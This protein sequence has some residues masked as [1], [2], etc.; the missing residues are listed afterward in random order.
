MTT[1]RSLNEPTWQ[2][3]GSLRRELLA[4]LSAGGECGQVMTYEEFLDW[5]D[6][7]TLAE[8]VDGKVEMTSPAGL[9]HQDLGD[10][11]GGVLSA[12]VRLYDLGKVV[13]APF[14]MK[15]PH[16]GREPDVLFVATA[17][18]GRLQPTILD[19]PADLVVEILSPESV[20]RDRGNKFFEYQEARIPEYWLIDPITQRAEFYQLDAQ[21][22]YTLVTPP[23][24]G[25]YRSPTLP[26]FWLSVAWLWQDPLPPV[27]RTMLSIDPDAYGRFLLEELRQQ[28]VDPTRNEP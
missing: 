7:D 25:L 26:G 18:L 21:G 15:L 24:S 14:Q 27:E 19:G 13:S 23:A 3:P 4:H 9:R 16:S 17:Y 2:I 1:A 11:L 5:A 20:G 8:W 10:F 6:E 22:V 28:G 12:F